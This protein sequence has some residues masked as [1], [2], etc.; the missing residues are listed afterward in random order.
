MSIVPMEDNLTKEDPSI[1]N[2]D[3]NVANK[4]FITNKDAVKLVENPMSENLDVREERTMYLKDDETSMNTSKKQETLPRSILKTTCHDKIKDDKNPGA[5]SF[6]RKSTP[7]PIPTRKRSIKYSADSNPSLNRKKSSES[8]SL[9]KIPLPL[10][11][12][13][14]S[15]RKRSRKNSITEVAGELTASCENLFDAMTCIG[16]STEKMTDAFID[17]IIQQSSKKSIDRGLDSSGDFLDDSEEV[18][19]EEEQSKRKEACDNIVMKFLELTGD[20]RK[21]PNPSVSLSP[22]SGL[23]AKRRESRA[24]TPILNLNSQKLLDGDIT[25]R[26]IVGECD[27]AGEESL[28]VWNKEPLNVEPTNASDEDDDRSKANEFEVRRL[29]MVIKNLEV[30]VSN[31]ENKIDSLE[32]E[33]KS[34]KATVAVKDQECEQLRR[35]VN[36]LVAMPEKVTDE[37]GDKD[38]STATEHLV[39]GFENKLA[40]FESKISSLESQLQIAKTSLEDKV[41]ECEDLSR[42]LKVTESEKTGLEAK[43]KDMDLEV[44]VKKIKLSDQD[45]ELRSLKSKYSQLEKELNEETAKIELLENKRKESEFLV[46]SLE[47]EVKSL[48][49]KLEMCDNDNDK[50]KDD[51]KMK[52]V[53]IDTKSSEVEE[54]KRRIEVLESD[55]SKFENSYHDA[56][57]RLIKM[58]Q[59]GEEKDAKNRDMETK[60]RDLERE[61]KSFNQK[62]SKYEEKMKELESS[63]FKN[64]R[65]FFDKQVEVVDTVCRKCEKLDKK[66]KNVESKLEKSVEEV[67]VTVKKLEAAN[68]A[69]KDLKFE[70]DE[71]LIKNEKFE[72]VIKAN[73]VEIIAKETEI[74]G[75]KSKIEAMESEVTE[76]ELKLKVNSEKFEALSINGEDLGRNLNVTKA[77]FEKLEQEVECLKEENGKLKE[78]YA[79]LEDDFKVSE[80]LVKVSEDKLTRLELALE[81]TRKDFHDNCDEL[82]TALDDLKSIE[83]SKQE[84]EIKYE[85]LYEDHQSVAKMLSEAE[86]NAEEAKRNLVKLENEN[87]KLFNDLENEKSKNETATRG[88]EEEVSELMNL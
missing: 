75:F 56:N 76:L 84:M 52:A 21:S 38:T 55:I 22:S 41:K 51:L 8:N 23:D 70:F 50:L 54:S 29:K 25:T 58:I 86:T 39:R 10:S 63:Q 61:V 11:N 6:S 27:V 46:N 65:A 9:S 37:V 28:K 20:K 80:R 45:E 79:I 83:A 16:D 49:M 32:D 53:I 14:K 3:V 44:S 7:D 15:G 74:Q 24:P 73:E 1:N 62:N 2:N 69:H 77:N 36:M 68:A 5:E 17:D 35:D 48:K 18:F 85:K 13:K 57:M 30:N 4:N 26:S 71:S 66:L 82:K 60:V 64:K 78:A 88:L 72:E 34:C 31:Y 47:I 40:L 67:E 43:T 12:V 87:E 19:E 59:D 81:T 33:L 42:E